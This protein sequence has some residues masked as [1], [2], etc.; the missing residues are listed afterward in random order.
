MA[1]TSLSDLG[2]SI[3]VN[4][5]DGELLITLKADGTCKA[6]WIVGQA[7]GNGTARGV[8]LDG[9][10]DELDGI[11]VER[12]DTDIDTAFTSGDAIEVVVPKS[13]KVYRVK[14]DP[15]GAAYAGEPVTMHA[16]TAGA[17]DNGG[18]AEAVH[19]GRLYRDMGASDTWAEIVWGV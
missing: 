5:Y 13:G 18:D 17:I 7:S 6:G 4:G 2:G 12:Y 1:N 11:A 3:F 10:L 14:A 19:I 8:D 15:T 9:N 16:T